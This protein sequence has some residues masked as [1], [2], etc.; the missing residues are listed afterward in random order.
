MRKIKACRFVLFLVFAALL[1]KT[2]YC[3]GA[4]TRPNV[5][6]I[7]ADDMGYNDIG[8]INHQ[9]TVTPTL[10]K[11]AADGV[12][13]SRHYTESSC[14]PSRV[15]LL[16]GMYPAKL[17]FHPEGLA[18]PNNIVTLPQLLKNNGYRTYLFGKWHAG[19]LISEA[20]PDQHG[21]EHW[22]G[23]LSHF[24]LAGT[25]RN[26][27]P[28]ANTPTYLNPWL[29]SESSAPQQYQ[30]HIDDLLTAKAI[31]IIHQ[32]ANAPWFIYA[33]FLSPHTPTIPNDKFRTKYPDTPN[34][35][36]R[37]VI[38]QLD[39]NIATLLTAVEGSGARDN[40]IVVFVSDNGATGKYFPSNAPFDGSKASY[41]EGGIR[42]PL[43][44]YWPK[45]W[46]GGKQIQD[47]KYIADIYPTIAQALGLKVPSD[48]DGENIFK[49]RK[50]PIYWYSQ[51]PLK[52]TFSALSTDGRWRLLG[53]GDS[54]RL[55]YYPDISGP[56]T[57]K[58]NP[59]VQ[60]SLLQKFLAWR[61]AATTMIGDG[62][63]PLGNASKAIAA[64][65]RPT[66][67]LGFSFLKP[68]LGD[69]S[70]IQLIDN[71]QLKL[72]YALGEFVLTLDS[73]TVKIPY[74]LTAQCNSI[75]L[76]FAV[77]QDNTIFYGDG[78]STLNLYVNGSQ[79]NKGE[80]K[81]DRINEKNFSELK[82]V[83]FIA[84]PRGQ[85]F[86]SSIGIASRL[87]LNDEIEQRLIAQTQKYCPQ[88]PLDSGNKI[89]SRH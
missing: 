20:S 66:F 42:T 88:S 4:E 54:A 36:Y 85:I 15:A 50:A 37:A 43:I 67:S 62:Q 56:P 18:L 84:Q 17:G 52:D 45:H 82:L 76:N 24:Y 35:R 26:G 49:P 60:A 23:T 63:R 48:V 51:S 28:V 75:Y 9:Q 87:F 68:S 21:F 81:I 61:N 71:R 58:D 12:L 57:P 8:F 83:D 80:F 44:V 46:Q 34:G 11:L 33:P 65:F 16:T 89:G 38:E 53:D 79:A 31:D 74:Q 13:F 72:V 69:Q 47:P 55:L 5:L 10:D 40:T 14:S 64:P 7:L 41:D 39:S 2:D 1:P 19:D 30:G 29:Q 70:T 27:H 86:G 25:T 78:K 3:Y 22:F 59:A 6:L 73:T 77:S 32:K